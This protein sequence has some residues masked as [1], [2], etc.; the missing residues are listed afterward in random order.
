MIDT[1]EQ[2]ARA[3]AEA[4]WADDNAT[5][6]LGMELR[7]VGPGSAT[8]A[9]R[10]QKRMTNGHK[11][12]HGGFLFTLAD[13]AF[14]FACNS[15]G[16]RTVAQHCMISY[17]APAFEGDE[18]IAVAREVSRQGRNGIYDVRISRADGVV[19][20]EFRGFSATIKGHLLGEQDEKTGL[21]ER[22]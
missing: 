13:S 18:L 10:V 7:A 17:L 21:G 19:I 9:M 4:M 2:L 15:Y 16:Q 5:N 3:C 22:R 6:D 12:C 14:A 1:P 11:T 8:M 20:A